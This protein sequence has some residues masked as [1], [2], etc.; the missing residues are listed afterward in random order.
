ML[1]FNTPVEF[2]PELQDL[3]VKREDQACQPP[4]PQFSKTRGV[5]AHVGQKVAEG[6]NVF[7]V[8]DTAHSQAGHAVAFASKILGVS[9]INFFPEFKGRPGPKPPQERAADLGATLVGLPAGMSAV[10]FHQAKRIMKETAKGITYM[11]PNALK[12]PETVTETAKEV[13]GDCLDAEVVLLSVSSGT[14]AAGVIRGY[15]EQG[16]SPLYLLHL[17]YSRSHD[18]LLNYIDCYQSNKTAQIRLVDEGYDYKD[19]ARKIHELSF[20]CNHW[21]DMKVV[22]WWLREGRTD[23]PTSKV[24]LWNVG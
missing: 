12:L 23:Y 5:F 15:L 20:P 10:L 19:R 7:G 4:G 22:D 18:Q 14:I 2:Y 1:N 16:K 11:M 21:Y 17:G 8:L 6:V 24:L 13:A 9:C 3:Y